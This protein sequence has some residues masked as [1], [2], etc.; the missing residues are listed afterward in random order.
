MSEN[1]QEELMLS[2]A[3]EHFFEMTKQLEKTINSNNSIFEI[4][5]QM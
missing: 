2:S 1:L 5:N 3:T 4:H